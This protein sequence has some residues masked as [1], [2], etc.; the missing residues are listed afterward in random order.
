MGTI[1]PQP[2]T[3]LASVLKMIQSHLNAIQVCCQIMQA[4]SEASTLSKNSTLFM[5]PPLALKQ[6]RHLNVEGFVG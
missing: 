2:F 3:Y 1:C 4:I 6:D 5:E